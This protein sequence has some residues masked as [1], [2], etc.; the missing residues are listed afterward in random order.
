MP[1]QLQ[2][3]LLIAEKINTA[4]SQFAIL[5]VLKKSL[6]LH[7]FLEN[8]NITKE[9]LNCAASCIVGDIRFISHIVL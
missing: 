6:P 8:S 2:Y 4:R 9:A 3:V 7:K 1:V 5:I